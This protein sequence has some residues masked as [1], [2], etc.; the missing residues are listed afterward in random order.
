MKLTHSIVVL[1]LAAVLTLGSACSRTS[2]IR[3]DYE[4][5]P[6]NP[7]EA[8]YSKSVILDNWVLNDYI[9]IVDSRTV[10][11]GDLLKA[12]VGVL[13]LTNDSQNLQY[14]FKWFDQNDLEIDSGGQAWQPFVLHGKETKN[15]Q[16]TA[17]NPT[18]RRFVV[19]IRTRD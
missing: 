19:T 11:V 7:E 9:K 5:T 13:S 1:G 15:L 14:K 12:Q 17:L 2:G 10:T 3:N 16:A 8:Y 18:A 4:K 6:P